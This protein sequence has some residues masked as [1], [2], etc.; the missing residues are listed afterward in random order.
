MVKHWPGGG[1]GEGGR[2][3]HYGNGKYAV[4]PGGCYADHRYPFEHGAFEL[5]G[6]TGRAE[7]SGLLPFELPA[8]M[9]AVE[10]HCEDRPHDIE[11]YTDACGNSY[12]FAFGLDFSGPIS[13]ART[14]RYGGRYKKA[15]EM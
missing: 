8:S 12:A 3:A 9:G 10:R 13:D 1:S 6:A 7:P 11:P 5:R 15:G 2:D 4:Y 14:R